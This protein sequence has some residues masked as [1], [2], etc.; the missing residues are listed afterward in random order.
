M[1]KAFLVIIFVSQIA[2]CQVGIGTI[3]PDGSAALDISSS[4][5][6]LL[7]PRMTESERTAI[8]DPANGLLIYQTNNGVGYWYYKINT[9]TFLSKEGDEDW[10]GNGENDVNQNIYT[11]GIV[12]IRQSSGIAAL[13]I[14]S[15]TTTPFTDGVIA[16]GPYTGISSTS[17][18]VIG[19]ERVATAF[20]SIY[21]CAGVTCSWVVF[22]TE[23]TNK[24]AF[25]VEQSGAVTI[26]SRYTLPL[27]DGSSGEFLTTDGD[28]NLS[29]QDPS[30]RLLN[31]ESV[32]RT[33]TTKNNLEKIKSLEEQ[34][35]LLTKKLNKLETLLLKSSY[36]R[37]ENEN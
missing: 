7:I 32:N 23:Y 28:G 9:W 25:E 11:R 15:N 18:L 37:E 8:A 2:F 34:V 27:E 19:K 35:D 4:N 12:D 21:S 26:N 36:K 6:G 5:S 17:K 13:T 1:K 24:N 10:K 33:Q 31:T 22:A 20:D 30:T 29:W 14:G 3:T 16:I